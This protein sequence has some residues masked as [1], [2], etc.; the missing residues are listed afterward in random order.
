[1]KRIFF[2]FLLIGCLLSN[3]QAQESKAKEVLDKASVA[4]AEAG[5]M[6]IAF[7]LQIKDGE[8]GINESFVGTM[9]IK[10][11]KFHIDTP[12]METWFDGKTQTVLQ[13]EWEEVNIS[14]ATDEQTQ[15][16]NPITL[17]NLYK[18]GSKCK[19]LG[20]KTDIKGRKVKE[21]ELTPRDKSNEIEKLVVQISDV[22]KLP[23]KLHLYYKNKLENI[24]HIDTYT[25]ND[26]LQDS[27]FVFDASKY[28][29]AEI[30]DLR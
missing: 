24:I 14:E 3:V 26:R 29:N 6:S 27:L 13:K 23:F 25:T 15:S 19:Y 30:I 10:G 12:D 16:L 9:N 4:F 21:I 18:D 28:P 2:L 11:A 7:S 20:E 8:Q 22:S 1:M 17:F 5:N